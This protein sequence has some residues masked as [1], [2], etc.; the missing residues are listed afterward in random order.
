[1]YFLMIFRMTVNDTQSNIFIIF[2]LGFLMSM[3]Y[4]C[5]C[6]SFAEEQHKA[7]LNAHTIDGTM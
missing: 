6:R 1:M 4:V 2:V 3:N 5:C 7:Q